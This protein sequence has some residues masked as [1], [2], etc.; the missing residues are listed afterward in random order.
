MVRL[1]GKR[2]KSRD[3]EVKAREC[4]AAELRVPGAPHPR[5]PASRIP[6][7]ALTLSLAAPPRFASFARPGL[8]GHRLGRSRGGARAAI[9]PTSRP[10]SAR[11]PPGSGQRALALLQLSPPLLWLVSFPPAMPSS[12]I[13]LIK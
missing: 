9:E 11:G 10:A 2:G 8:R 3:L 6:H 4:T 1:E 7:P 12:S 5:S 13:G